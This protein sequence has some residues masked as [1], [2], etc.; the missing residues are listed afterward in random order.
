[1]VLENIVSQFGK[2]CLGLAGIWAGDAGNA[3]AVA[4]VA[5]GVYDRARA[6]G[7]EPEAVFAC[8]LAEHRAAWA[9]EYAREADRAAIDAVEA[10]LAD[11]LTVVFDPD[12]LTAAAFG[13]RGMYAAAVAAVVGQLGLDDP[14][15]HS[16]TGRR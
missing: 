6:A 16:D 1:M 13:P 2:L 3:A 10:L 14:R 11:S 4:E 9:A 12:A 8:V 7:K 5:A 15:Q